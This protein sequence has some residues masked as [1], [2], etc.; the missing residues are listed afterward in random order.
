MTPGVRFA[1]LGGPVRWAF[2]GT[3]GVL[4]AGVNLWLFRPYVGD[5]VSTFPVTLDFTIV[6]EAAWLANPYSNVNYLWSPLA[7]YPLQLITLVGHFGWFVLHVLALLPLRR[8][9]PVVAVSFPFWFDITTGN[10]MTFV[11]VAAFFAVQGNRAAQVGFVIL[12][13][14]M[15]RPLMVPL[16]LW[17]L[18][19][20]PWIRP[21][22]AGLVVINAVLVLA[23]GFAFDWLQRL[24][25]VPVTM[26]AEANLS[27]SRWLGWL[28]WPVGGT[29]AL[30]A[31]RLGRI[32]LASVLVQP[33]LYPQY[34]MMGLAELG[35]L[36]GDRQ[37]RDI[38]S[39]P[40]E[41]D[42]IRDD[43]TALGDGNDPRHVVNE[44]G[45]E[46]VVHP[47]LERPA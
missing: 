39:A 32:G 18:W 29:L 16:V 44:R 47:I 14:L 38:A 13:L 26:G 2:L 20:E 21:W 40:G 9:A 11:G 33:Y 43:V 8:W 15:P 41:W 25:S 23:S 6:R 35:Q 46:V 37:V 30:V 42:R 36:V 17:L 10:V 3:A 12:A 28:W 1:A 34:L 27:P 7:V 45:D 24:A 22:V 4:W 5:L 31:L 19:K